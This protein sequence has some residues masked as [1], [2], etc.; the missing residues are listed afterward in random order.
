M[1]ILA[2]LASMWYFGIGIIL[3]LMAYAMDMPRLTRTL[4]IIVSG[5]CIGISLTILA[6][7]A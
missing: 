1:S 6:V 7:M 4:V 5:F 3:V 2:Q